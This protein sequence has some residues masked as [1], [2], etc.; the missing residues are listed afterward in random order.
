M[1]KILLPVLALIISA[2]ATQA[3]NAPVILVVDVNA[4]FDASP[5]I[6]DARTGLQREAQNAE[7][8]IRR[9]REEH[10]QL[11]QNARELQATANN[12]ALTTDAKNK[13]TD[14][15]QQ[16]VEQIG[17]LEQKMVQF[18]QSTQQ[19]LTS[20]NNTIHSTYFEQIKQAVIEIAVQRNAALV[21][22]KT[23]QAVI[24]S[25]EAVDITDAVIK[26]LNPTR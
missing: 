9:M 2:V 21:L 25:S 12:P 23:P 1:K 13:A 17:T 4:I 20:R 26:L 6:Q 22:N 3:Q 18:Q 24:Y 14:E 7:I 15:L 10:S 16:L 19:E 8:E 5:R 11:M